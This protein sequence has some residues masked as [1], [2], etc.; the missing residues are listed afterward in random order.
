M[1]F[2]TMNPEKKKVSQMVADFAYNYI[3]MGDGVEEK[4]Q[5]LNGAVTAWNIACLDEKFRAKAIKRYMKDF[6]KMNPQETPQ[7]YKD[8]EEN[9]RLLIKTKD[10]LYPL[11]RIQVASA[12]IEKKGGKYHLS[13]MTLDM[14]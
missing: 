7:F 6:R 8:G 3:A 14:L 13:V 4:Q 10:N 11:V 1:F 9:L 5:N 2:K 12:R